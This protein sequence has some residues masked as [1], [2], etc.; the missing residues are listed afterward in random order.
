L[1]FVL[2]NETSSDR[3]EDDSAS[4]EEVKEEKAVK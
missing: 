1:K 3:M 4:E 2:L